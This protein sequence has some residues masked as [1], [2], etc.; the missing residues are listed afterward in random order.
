[1]VNEPKIYLIRLVAKLQ[2]PKEIRLFTKKEWK[3]MFPLS[4]TPDEISTLFSIDESQEKTW[5][6]I[7]EAIKKRY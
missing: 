6:T 4:D 5:I 1:L 7:K 3:D 2:M